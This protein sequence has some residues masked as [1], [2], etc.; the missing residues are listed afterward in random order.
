MIFFV[1]CP[2]QRRG[3]KC[4][5][6]IFV[7]SVFSA[8]QTVCADMPYNPCHHSLIEIYFRHYRQ[9]RIETPS[10]PGGVS[11]EVWEKQYSRKHREKDKGVYASSKDKERERDR[12]RRNRDRHRGM[13]ACFRTPY[14]Q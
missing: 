13:Y 8:K 12:D 4:L 5:I 14:P 1:C 9:T 3:A 7:Y 2:C 6:N 10:H 11:S